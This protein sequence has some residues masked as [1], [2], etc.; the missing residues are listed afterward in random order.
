MK[1]EKVPYD[2]GIIQNDNHKASFFFSSFKTCV[3]SKIIYYVDSLYSNHI[4]PSAVNKQILLGKY[5]NKPPVIII[6]S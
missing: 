4:L 3:G 5:L 2:Y 1:K 6:K